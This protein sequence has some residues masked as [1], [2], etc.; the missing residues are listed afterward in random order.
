MGEDGACLFRSVG[1]SVYQV[2]CKIAAVCRFVLELSLSVAAVVICGV[3][4]RKLSQLCAYIS[5]LRD[6]VWHAAD[7]P[8]DYVSLF[9]CSYP[10]DSL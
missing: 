3:K 10:F 7:F 5:I 1:K 2:L 6:I 8:S 9:F 4:L